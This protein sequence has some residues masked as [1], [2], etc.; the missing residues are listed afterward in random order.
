[1]INTHSAVPQA[2]IAGPVLGH[3]FMRNMLL[4]FLI[5]ST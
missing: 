4:L 5:Q 1:M 3:T 2:F